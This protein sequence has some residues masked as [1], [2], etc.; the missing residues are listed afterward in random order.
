MIEA[1]LTI[2]FTTAILL[3]SP[4]PAPIALAATGAAQ[5]FTRGLPFLCGIL[6]GS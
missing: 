2:A 6:L 4:G 5:G 3:G 1:L